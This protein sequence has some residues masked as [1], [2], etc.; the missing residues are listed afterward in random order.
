MAK[1]PDYPPDVISKRWE[2]YL[3]ALGRVAHTWNHFQDALGHLFVRVA[4][5]DNS[6]GF[7]IWYS[8]PDDRAQRR[9]LQ[10][11]IDALPEDEFKEYPTVK[12]DLAW[13]LEEAN[14]IADKRN[15]AVH[16]PCMLTIGNGKFELAPSWFYGHP[17]A[18]KLRGKDI[19]KE[20]SW[21]D[22]RASTLTNYA[23]AAATA[24]SSRQGT[25]PERPLMP[26]LGQRSTHRESHRPRSQK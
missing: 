19:L 7:G 8:T 9:M 20:F 12:A 4:N 22:Q 5:L 13:I 23:R 25:W 14:K 16:A 10:T 1:L 3:A 18:L 17:R 11:V 15:D 24:L 26:T 21:C 6:V 2:P